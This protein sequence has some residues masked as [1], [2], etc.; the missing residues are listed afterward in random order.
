MYI[1]FLEQKKL[2]NFQFV[3]SSTKQQFFEDYNGTC[4]EILCFLSKLITLI[5]PFTKENEEKEE[6]LYEFTLQ[7]KN[8]ALDAINRQIC[9]CEK[10]QSLVFEKNNNI[11]YDIID[12]S[13]SHF[14]NLKTPKKNYLNSIIFDPNQRNQNK[15]QSSKSVTS[16]EIKEGTEDDGFQR[17]VSMYNDQPGKVVFKRK[18]SKKKFEES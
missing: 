5:L 6:S 1:Y 7:Q 13:T 8:T 10:L 11:N 4:S 15:T 14:E 2:A 18:M 17:M 16:K 9:L 12:S 3:A